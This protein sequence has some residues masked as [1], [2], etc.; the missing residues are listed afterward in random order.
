VNESEAALLSVILSSELSSSLNKVDRYFL[1]LGVTN[2]VITLGGKGVYWQN[3][4]DPVSIMPARK[5]KVVNTTAAGDT[6]I[7]T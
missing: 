6:F 5:V 2:L 1:Q 4:V 7:G 3:T